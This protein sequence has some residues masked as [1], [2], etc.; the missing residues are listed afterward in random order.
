MSI[1]NQTIFYCKKCNLIQKGIL[2]DD[3]DNFKKHFNFARTGRCLDK[4]EY[5]DAYSSLLDVYVYVMDIK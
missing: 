2:D 4:N 3:I 5:K 1:H